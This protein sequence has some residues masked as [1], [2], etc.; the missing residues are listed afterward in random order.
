MPAA[1]INWAADHPGLLLIGGCGLLVGLAVGLL[2]FSGWIDAV[3]A[4]ARDRAR[5]DQPAEGA[6]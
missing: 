5:D 6:E 3:D 4:L 2:M 1:L